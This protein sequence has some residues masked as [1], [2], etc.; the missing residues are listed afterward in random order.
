MFLEAVL[1]FYYRDKAKL[2]FVYDDHRDFGSTMDFSTQ[3]QNSI[4]MSQWAEAIV[5][6][7]GK[8]GRN[9]L[10]KTK[11]LPDSH[12][13]VQLNK[14]LG[15]QRKDC[16]DPV[17]RLRLSKGLHRCRYLMLKEKESDKMAFFV[18][19]GKSPISRPPPPR[20][21]ALYKLHSDIIYD[22]PDTISEHVGNFFGQLFG[23]TRENLPE[24]IF[25]DKY[26]ILECSILDGHFLAEICRDLNRNK[27]N[28]LAR[29]MR[30]GASYRHGS[31]AT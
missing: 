27:I 3:H 15:Q 22:T 4:N 10:G 16:V 5:N 25:E 31:F 1:K 29:P 26:D 17:M 2:K 19:F 18:E 7:A 11:T 23:N 6:A 8:H 30:L 14:T 21:Y 13:L 12:D 20:A 28:I 9:R 24:W